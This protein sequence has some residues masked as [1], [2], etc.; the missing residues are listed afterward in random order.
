MNFLCLI[1]GRGFR[2]EFCRF[3]LRPG[4]Y[5]YNTVIAN[6]FIV[7][8]KDANKKTIFQSVLSTYE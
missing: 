7:N 8:I 5:E 6:Q 4:K 3:Q 1:T 2:G